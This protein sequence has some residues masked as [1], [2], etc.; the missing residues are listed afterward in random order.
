M[1]P[2]EKA[3]AKIYGRVLFDVVQKEDKSTWNDC[4]ARLG[5]LVS[6]VESSKMLSVALQTPATSSKEK[7]ALVEVLVKKLNAP[8]ILRRFLLLLVRK[9]RLV[10]L[11][12]ITQALDSVRLEAGGGVMGV[13]TSAEALSASD[14]ESLAK[15]FAKKLGKSVEFVSLVNP[16]LLAGL[17]VTVQGVTY[18]GTLRAQ[19][20]RLRDQFS[21]I[22]LRH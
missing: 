22:S 3:I 6:L 5:D 20:E 19:L 15:A 4:R 18:D 1:S 7:A 14:T 21:G 12:E 16:E 8:A 9:G 17:K 10:L 13:L 2:K 11:S